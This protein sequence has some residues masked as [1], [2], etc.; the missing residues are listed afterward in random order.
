MDRTVGGLVFPLPSSK[1]SE[2]TST[3][4]LEDIRRHKH[5]MCGGGERKE[6]RTPL[7]ST[8]DTLQKQMRQIGNLVNYEVERQ[9]Q[10]NYTQDGS[11]FFP[12]NKKDL[13][14][15]GFKNN[16]RQLEKH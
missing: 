12:R 16:A 6:G 8:R 11:L 4:S 9:R 10:T 1:A 2:Y 13:P 7:H 5:Y 14:W 3:L 15:E